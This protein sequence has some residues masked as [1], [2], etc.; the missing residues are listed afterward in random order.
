MGRAEDAVRHYER[1]LQIKPQYVDAHLG[2]GWA[3][4]RLGRRVKPSDITTGAGVRS[5]FSHRQQYAG[6]VARQSIGGR[7]AWRLDN[8][9]RVM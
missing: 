2:T 4:F 8:C 9:N 5:E 7:R 3:L 1:A 6:A